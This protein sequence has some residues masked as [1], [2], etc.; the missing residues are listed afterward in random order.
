MEE[1]VFF[2]PKNATSSQVVIKVWTGAEKRFFFGSLKR[3][4][5][6]R[7]GIESNPGPVT[8]A[9]CVLCKVYFSAQLNKLRPILK[10]EKYIPIEHIL[11]PA[12]SSARE[13]NF[14]S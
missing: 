13:I 10:F 9:Q 2:G 3:N 6:L 1:G 11:V 5:L 14:L 7:E 12:C 8:I 4:L